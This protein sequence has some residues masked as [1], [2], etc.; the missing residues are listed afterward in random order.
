MTDSDGHEPIRV[1][2]LFQL[3]WYRWLPLSAMDFEH[4]LHRFPDLSRREA[5]QAQRV[6]DARR[7]GV[8]LD[9]N[10]APDV[11]ADSLPAAPAWPAAARPTGESGDEQAYEEELADQQRRIGEYDEVTTSLGIH[12]VRTAEQVLDLMITL[13]LIEVEAA[14]EGEA[15]RLAANPPLPTEVL[16]LSPEQRAEEDRLRWRSRYGALS[17]RVL[18]LFIHDASGGLSRVTLPTSLDRL[19]TAIGSDAEDVRHAVQVL[20][21]EGDFSAQRQGAPV[22]AERLVPHQ[23][24]DLVVDPSRFYA[25]RISVQL[26]RPVERP[27]A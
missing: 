6:W 8:D 10:L 19:A 12:P 2:A 25:D 16:P 14:D 26:N 3:G 15:L 23:R 18:R 13:G 21:D 4:L 7:A 9:N 27:D 17:Q 5:V 20:I 1:P 22:D 24:F 11:L